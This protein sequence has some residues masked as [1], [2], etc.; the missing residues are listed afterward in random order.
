MRKLTL[1][2][3]HA[4]MDGARRIA[5][6][7][8]RN[9]L[10]I[11]E[12]LVRVLPGHG[13]ALELASGTGQHVAAFGR[14][15]PGLTWQP[16]DGTEENLPSIA[17]W[18]GA[19]AN[20]LPPVRLDACQPGWAAQWNGLDVL[21]LT[22]LLHLISDAEAWVLLD[23]VAQ[24]LAPGGVFCLY[25]PFRQAG[26]LISDGDA[27]FDAALKAQDPAIGYKDIETVMARLTAAGLTPDTPIPMP[28]N[29][30]MLIARRA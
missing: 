24:A 15:F 18:C 5:P 19:V 23:E 22:N 4:A 3:S 7:A 6:S 2:D 10:P 21:C 16:S 28:A 8:G 25:G 12:V 13:R 29:N 30:L 20:V 26:K 9:L 11:T 27:A 17:A 1:P 14:H